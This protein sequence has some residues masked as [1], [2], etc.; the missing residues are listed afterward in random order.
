MADINDL[1]VVDA[2]N[3]ARFPEGQAPS[4][5][6][7]GAR[8]LEGIVARWNKDTD[9]SLVSTG[10]AN[11][12]VLAAN[13][14]LSAYYDGL[15]L[16][17][18]ANFTNTA[19]PTL[20]VDAVSAD[21]I[22]W[23][24]QTVLVAGDIVL[25]SKVTVKH[26]GTSWQLMTRGA[27][28]TA[29][30][31]DTGV[32]DGNVIQADATGLP[33]ID[34]SQLTGML[35][36]GHI[37]G[38]RVS[39]GT[40]TSNDLDIAVGEARDN[41]DTAD[42]VLAGAITRQMDV[43]FGTGNGG[44]SSSLTKTL[45]TSYHVILCKDS[46]GT[47]TV[48]FDTSITGATLITDHSIT[49]ARRICSFTT[50]GSNNITAFSQNGDDFLI[51]YI[52]LH[53][54]VPGATTAFLL[55]LAVVPSGVQFEAKLAVGLADLNSVIGSLG[56]AVYALITPPDL[57][58][59]VPS[60]SFYSVAHS[61]HGTSGDDDHDTTYMN[62]RTNT[63]GQVRFRQSDVAAGAPTLVISVHG[64]K[65]DRGKNGQFV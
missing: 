60:S 56:G 2:S 32:A 64:W 23:P 3:T 44:L 6:N 28:G 52:L 48:G 14:T 53:A 63:S 59:T 1:E 37:F 26:D 34:G 22:V 47:V 19:A 24:D 62:V 11:A 38:L 45:S 29:A 58:D 20:I 27:L 13:Q 55:T 51:N 4:T 46:G 42:L 8:A 9:G 49:N 10:S 61:I 31:L 18:D 40:D 12:Y 35:P 16:T 7:N 17:F 50:D 54:S 36:S 65:D 43:A 33:A 25:G 30:I 21:P 41:A 5:V 39:T 57:S 15:T